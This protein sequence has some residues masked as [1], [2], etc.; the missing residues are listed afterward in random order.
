MLLAADRCR[1][2]DW[3]ERMKELHAKSHYETLFSV[4]S[5]FITFSGE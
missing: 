2:V 5:Y 1:R 4:Y 3:G